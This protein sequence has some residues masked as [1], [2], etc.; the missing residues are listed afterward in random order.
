MP[1]ILE[2]KNNFFIFK[3]HFHVFETRCMFLL[4]KY[5][6]L[7]IR[8]SIFYMRKSIIISII[9]YLILEIGYFI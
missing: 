2:T 3:I 9:N 5:G 4:K 8:I 7:N 6:F 1:L